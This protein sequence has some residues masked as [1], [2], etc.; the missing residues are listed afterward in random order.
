[1]KVVLGIFAKHS[2]YPHN[3]IEC[4]DMYLFQLGY[5]LGRN[6]LHQDVQKQE[7]PMWYSHLWEL[8]TRVITIR[9]TAGD[10]LHLKKPVSFQFKKMDIKF[11]LMYDFFKRRKTPLNKF[12]Y[13]QFVAK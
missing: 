13:E 3:L 6:G 1:L 4:T 9:Y 2:S 10:L 8:S 11:L 5:Y 12:P 7:Q